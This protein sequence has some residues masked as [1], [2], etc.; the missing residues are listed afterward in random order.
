LGEQGA[1]LIDDLD[2]PLEERL[3]D[4]GLLGHLCGHQASVHVSLR[5]Q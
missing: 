2:P 3:Q 4:R 5:V 1:D